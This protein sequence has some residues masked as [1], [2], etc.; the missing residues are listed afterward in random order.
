LPSLLCVCGHK[1]FL[2]AKNM[3]INYRLFQKERDFITTRL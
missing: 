3:K 2:D 1:K